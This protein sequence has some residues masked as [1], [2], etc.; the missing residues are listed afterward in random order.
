MK[1]C[2]REKGKFELDIAGYES[3]VFLVEDTG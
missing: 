2:L 1:N 3:W